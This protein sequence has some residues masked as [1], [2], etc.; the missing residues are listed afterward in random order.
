MTL[1]FLFFF[2]SFRNTKSVLEGFWGDLHWGKWLK[3]GQPQLHQPKYQQQQQQQ[4]QQQ[5]QQ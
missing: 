3:P 4:Q 2:L 5:P 1:F